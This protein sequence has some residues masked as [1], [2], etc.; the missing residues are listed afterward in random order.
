MKPVVEETC[1]SCGLCVGTCPE[2]FQ[3]GDDGKSHAI[4]DS[5]PE[6]HESAAEE[7]RDGCPV[8]AISLD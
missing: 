6:E 8:A 5:V 4:V 3:F 7:A 2:V 1:I